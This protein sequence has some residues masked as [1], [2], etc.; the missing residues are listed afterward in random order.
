MFLT[1]KKLSNLYA[2]NLF[3]NIIPFWEEYSIDKEYGGYLTSLDLSGKVFDTDKFTWM[4]ARQL[5]MFSV[6]SQRKDAPP[7]WLKIAKNGA[8]FLIKFGR[9]K[10]CN[11]YYGLTRE[12]KPLFQPFSIFTEGFVSMAFSQYAK[13]TGDKEAKDIAIE[14]YNSFLERKSAPKGRYSKSFPSTRP[15]TSLSLRMI[16]LNLLLELDWLLDT[17]HLYENSQTNAD[18]IM[19]LFLD[20]KHNLLFENVSPDGT[21]ID[22]YEG[23]LINPGHGIEVLWMLMANIKKF[24]LP[25]EIEKINKIILDTLEYGW[26][27]KY[28]GI[29]YRKD[30][31]EK[32]PLQIEWDQKMWWCHAEAILALSMGYALTGNKSNWIWLKKLHRYTWTHYV[33]NKHGEWFGYLNR[34]GIPILDLKG[35][36]WKGCFHIPRALL[37]SSE[38]LN[39]I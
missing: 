26:D 33:D 1:P 9:D 31:L 15:M 14:A 2:R 3:G 4:Q 38:Y 32:P 6:L 16:H 35:G 23:R 7:K 24:N 18:D 39:N 34:K 12:G 20:K 11:W 28:G 29:I 19:K 36:R 21:K 25:I 5:W 30:I 17:K 22:T 8:D 27:T 10:D 37:L 13:I